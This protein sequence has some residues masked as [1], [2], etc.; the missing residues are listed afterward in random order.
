MNRWIM[1]K[2]RNKNSV[3]IILQTLVVLSIILA[4]GANPLVRSV[5]FFAGCSLVSF[6]YFKG[7]VRKK[8]LLVAGAVILYVWVDSCLLNSAPTDY[9]ECVLL[10]ARIICCVMVASC[11]PLCR[12]K[13]LFINI[14]A[15]LSAFSLF[16]F[17]VYVFGRYLPGTR[18]IDGWAGTFYQTIGYGTEIR[19][20]ARIRNCGIFTEP[21]VYQMYLNAAILAVASSK[22]IAIKTARKLFVLFSITLFSTVSSMGYILFAV[23]IAIVFVEYK[24]LL[25]FP[26]RI[27]QK[28]RITLLLLILLAIGAFELLFGQI[29]DFILRTNSW[30]SRHDDAILSALIAKDYPFFGVGLATNIESIW[31]HYYSAYEDLRIYRAYQN[32]RSCGLGNYLAMGGIPFTCIYMIQV[33]KNFEGLYRFEAVVS[34]ILVAFIFVMFV[35]E[36]PLLSTP[37]FLMAFFHG[38]RRMNGVPVTSKEKESGNLIWQKKTVID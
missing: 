3:E 33:I 16:F 1:K 24:E 11:L 28:S 35:L 32:A 21:G 10:T 34:K 13:S 26:I 38:D 15:V 30:A 14:M 29:S 9:R 19:G 31:R 8:D 7:K 25:I 4:S 27:N 22:D 20:V 5:Y 36:E 6:L 12:F 2:I 18:Y 17:A 37:F 23:V